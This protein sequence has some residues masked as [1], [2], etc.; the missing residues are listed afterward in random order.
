[1]KAKIVIA[2]LALLLGTITT[3]NADLY[4]ESPRGVTQAEWNNSDSYKNFNCPS[5]YARGEGV[6]MNFTT[7]RADDFWFVNC[8][9]I[10]VYE[11]T[12]IYTPTPTPTATQSETSTATVVSTVT[13]PTNNTPS[14]VVTDTSTATTDTATATITNVTIDSLYTQIMALFTQLLALIAKLNR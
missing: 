3:A 7:N 1:M 5:G 14:N 13:T 2:V 6:D 9:P 10:V 12:P 8:S 11:P 4:V